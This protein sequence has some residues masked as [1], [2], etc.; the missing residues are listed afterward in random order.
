[1]PE[2]NYLAVVVAAVA[3][4][5]VGG[6]WYS[7]LLFANAWMRENRFT[8]EDVRKNFSP[9]RMYG[10]A[11]LCALLMSFAMAVLL[12]LPGHA[13]S[14]AG[15]GAAWRVMS[16]GKRG[17]ALGVCWIAMA[18]ATSYAFEQRSLKL[19]LINAGYHTV[20]CTVMGAMLGFMTK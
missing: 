16:G 6:L 14:P 10:I 17:F 12:I 7:P 18:F 5:V 2:V 19:W 8:L 20:Q 11:L 13:L 4:F 9:A 15:A 1:M 3:G